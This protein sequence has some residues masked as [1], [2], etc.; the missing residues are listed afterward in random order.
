M[1]KNG[2]RKKC[3]VSVKSSYTVPVVCE[4]AG[5]ITSDIFKLYVA[6][7]GQIDTVHT[8]RTDKRK[9]FLDAL[10][11]AHIAYD[12]YADWLVSKKISI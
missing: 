12:V 11:E 7:V 3:A 2:K 4:I 1:C 9:M 6:R 10:D 8:M 5:C